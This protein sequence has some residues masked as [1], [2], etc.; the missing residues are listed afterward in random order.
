MST[1]NASAVGL[2]PFCPAFRGR[3]WAEGCSTIAHWFA[4]TFSPVFPFVSLL[5][6]SWPPWV[7][8]AALLKDF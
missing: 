7:V 2:A 4:T 5:V 1:S 6:D 3:R 8:V